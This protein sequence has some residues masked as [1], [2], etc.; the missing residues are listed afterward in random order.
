MK[1]GLHKYICENFL[2]YKTLCS[3]IRKV[4]YEKKVS[5][6]TAWFQVELRSVGL[7]C[8]IQLLPTFQ[9]EA[10]LW[11][12]KDAV[13]NRGSELLLHSMLDSLHHSLEGN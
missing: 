9:W 6:R 4:H 3:K 11:T 1:Y 13:G 8:L 12:P 10:G 5:S 7:R 2:S